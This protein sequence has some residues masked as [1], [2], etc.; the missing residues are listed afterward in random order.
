MERGPSALQGS[1]RTLSPVGLRGSSPPASPGGHLEV[2][3]SVQGPSLGPGRHCLLSP[4][5]SAHGA[6]PQRPPGLSAH[7]QSGAAASGGAAASVSTRPREFNPG[8]HFVFLSPKETVELRR[9]IGTCL[10]Q[11]LTA[12]SSQGSKGHGE[13]RNGIPRSARPR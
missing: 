12:T 13:S 9:E 10:P 2:A 6:R 5:G 7:P 11:P 8:R 4:R 3:P 1:R